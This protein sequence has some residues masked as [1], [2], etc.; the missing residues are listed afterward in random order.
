VIVDYKTGD[1]EA[2]TKL[3]SVYLKQLELYKNYWEK[4]SSQEVSETIL[5]K[6]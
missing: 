5:Y 2:D 4:I 6:I 3:K 1:F